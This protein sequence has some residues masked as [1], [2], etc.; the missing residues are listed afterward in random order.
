MAIA[1]NK[2]AFF[3]YEILDTFEAG[4][5]LKGAEVKAI[6]AGRV[7]LKDSF[8]KIIKSEAFVFGMHISL[9]ENAYAFYR[10]KED[11]ERKLLLN[12]REIDYLHGKASQKELTIVPI[13][14][15]ALRGKIKL[16]IA[17]GKGK[18]LYDKRESLK[19]KAIKRDLESSLKNL[20]H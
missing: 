6:R 3:D 11:R 20:A 2:K 7:Q 16:E 15:Y 19:Q 9:F 12:R 10:P 17:L 14:I 5:V 1:K 18:K 4:L 13:K 8:V